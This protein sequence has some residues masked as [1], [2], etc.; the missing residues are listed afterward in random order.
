MTNETQPATQVQ[1]PGSTQ[2][3]AIQSQTTAQPEQAAQAQADKAAI[4]QVK[5]A[6]QTN[7][8][9]FQR[10]FSALT[11]KQKELF[12]KE[13]ELNSKQHLIDKYERLEKL[14]SEKPLDFLKENGLEFDSLAK[15]M[16]E[17][18]EPPTVEK[19]LSQLEAKIAAYEK[20]EKEKLERSQK[21]A[22]Q[23]SIDDY[24]NKM[25]DHIKTQS[26]KYEMINADEAY[27]LVFQVIHEHYN[28]TK[29]EYGEGEIL[30]T[31]KAADLVEKHL[32]SKLEK[33]KSLKKFGAGLEAAPAQQPKKDGFAA[34]INSSMVPTTT[35]PRPTYKSAEE[36]LQEAAKL[37]KWN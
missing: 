17:D 13:K 5:D 31:E 6:E 1:T 22:E 33:Y 4:E 37:L 16:L 27:D 14:K 24:K 26:D 32:E 29:S 11:R 12:L 35:P 3:G 19:K 9:E 21:D 25:K 8:P 2:I 36:S 15:A 10:K 28:K 18:G 23:K 7:D 34:T 30:D 20:A